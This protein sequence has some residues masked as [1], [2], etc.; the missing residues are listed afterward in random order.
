MIVVTTNSDSGAGSL[1]QAIA[2]AAVGEEITFNFTGT[3][4]LTSATLTITQDVIITGPGSG[5]LTVH[6]AS[7][8]FR[9]FTMNPA[10]VSISGM[11]IA[12]GLAAD[13]AGILAD[14]SLTLTDVIIKDCGASNS[15]GGIINYL[16]LTLTNCTIQNCTAITDGGGI[17]NDDGTVIATNLIL[18]DCYAVGDGGG[19]WNGGG[20]VTHTG[21]SITDNQADGVG[22][23]ILNTGTYT[24][25]DLAISGN[26]PNGI[27]NSGTIPIVRCTL[28]GNNG[29]LD[30]TGTVTIDNSTLSGNI[31]YAVQNEFVL[32]ITHS[33]ITNNGSG[34]LGGVNNSA[35]ANLTIQNTIFCLNTNY[36]ITTADGDCTSNGN[37]IFGVAIVDGSPGTLSTGVDDQYNVTS[38]QLNLGPLQDNGGPTFTHALLVGSVAI[39]AGNNVS[40]PATDQRGAGFSRVINGTIDIG[41]FES[42]L[43]PTPPNP[44]TPERVQQLFDESKC[45]ECHAEATEAQLLELALLRRW[46]I[47]V[48]PMAATDTQTLM[49]DGKCF[50]CYGPASEYETLKLALLAKIAV[51]VNPSA[52]VTPQGLLTYGNCF[53]CFSESDIH[54][55]MELALLDQIAS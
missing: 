6:R 19:I 53:S 47:S 11:T 28:S 10:T 49:S 23:G 36:D 3:I 38:V 5:L 55:T 32:G 46:L 14:G 13:G 40:A 30:N 33:T 24:P 26:V 15:G 45:Y 17:Y 9:V 2:D 1:R 48:D 29:G 31:N 22:G 16:D 43:S 54:Q 50:A 4:G 7:G 20:D 39:D 34:G 35:A 37:N 42:N 51:A 27:N 25:T 41:A 44:V 21:G 12:D 52:I 8:G 18:T